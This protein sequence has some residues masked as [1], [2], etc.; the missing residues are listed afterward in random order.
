MSAIIH[1]KLVRDR[2]PDIIREEGG[3]PVVRTLTAD[4]FRDA[5]GAKLIEEAQELFRS[6][7]TGNAKAILKE[8]ADV[9]EVILAA[10]GI[11]GLTLD[12]LLA[13]RDRRLR[14]RGGFLKMQFLEWVGESTAAVESFEDAPRLFLG[15]AESPRLINLIKSELARSRTAWIASAFYSPGLMNLLL[16]DF[17]RFIAEGCDLRVILSTMGNITRP[18]HLTHLRDVVPGIQLRV[19]HPPDIPFEEEPPS[20]HLKIYLF[21]HVNGNGSLL[22]GS[23]NLTEAG[24]CRNIEWNYFSQS[25]INL[26]FEDR[27]PFDKASEAFRHYWENA[28]VNVSDDF[29]DGYRKRFKPQLFPQRTGEPNEIEQGFTGVFDSQKAFAVAHGRRITPNEA[30][31]EALENLSLLRSRGIDKAAVI[32]ATGVGKTYLAALDFKQTGM[33]SLLFIAHRETLLQAAMRSFRTV[34]GD[35]RF[36]MFVGGGRHP[37]EEAGSVFA[38]IQTLSRMEHLQKFTPDSFE[39]VVLDE[40]HHAEAES[41]RKVIGHFKPA[42]FLGLT[43]TPERMD[44]QDVLALCDRNIAYELRLLDAVDRGLLTPFQYYAIHDPVDYDKISWRGTHYDLDELTTAL[45]ND[46]RTTIIATNLKRYLPP[47]GKT[48]ALAFCTSVSHARY[49]AHALARDHGIPSLAL[50]GEDP[51]DRRQDVIKRLQDENDPLQVICTVDIFNEGIDI[52]EV[53][54]I[55]FLRPTQSFTVFL[56]QLGRGLRL[57]EGKSFVVVMDFVGNFR[58]AHVAPLALKGYTSEA[59]FAEAVKEGRTKEAELPHGCFLDADLEVSRIWDAEIQRIIRG[60]LTTSEMLKALYLEIKEDLGDSSPS[61]LDFVGNR[62]GVD[63]HKFILHFKGWLRAKWYCEEGLPEPEEALLD[64]PGEAFLKHVEMDLNPSK[65]YKMVVL[66]TILEMPGTRWH[67]DAIARGFVDYFLAY[68]DRMIDYEELARF[69]DPRNFPLRKV[70]TKLKNMPLHFLSNTEDDYF[71]LDKRRGI[72]ELKREVVQYWEM[73]VFRAMVKE[74]VEYAL[75][76]YFQRTRA[77]KM[78]RTP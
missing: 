77:P 67:V 69:T 19:F 1:R 52:P 31:V 55:L 3:S 27:S 23:S 47:S 60:E 32:A 25:E 73:P 10:I 50:T 72:F 61:L 64:T 54:H 12:D 53:T 76:R 40:F 78:E 41:Y 43:A 71:I 34:L 36:G 57:K 39:Y 68:E 2:V 24:F 13:E 16:R 45:E 17:T 33:R 14:D 51:E 21:Q 29:L 26:P 59:D 56:Q 58:R 8:S 5:V 75:V 30:Q 46:T 35:P 70:I 37:D 6:W 42:F 28:T 65:S 20:F 15:P 44:G 74:R 18:E 9:L 11:H 48:R 63:P 62:R 4:E 66:K 49:T 7:R 38:M 22:I